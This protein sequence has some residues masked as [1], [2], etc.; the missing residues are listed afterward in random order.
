MVKVEYLIVRAPGPAL[1]SSTKRWVTVGHDSWHVAKTC[2]SE[3]SSVFQAHL[4]RSMVSMK[5][6]KI[7]MAE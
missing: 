6:D 2:V 7:A 1:Y 3:L 4:R 5:E